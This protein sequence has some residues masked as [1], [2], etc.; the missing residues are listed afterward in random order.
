MKTREQKVRD[1]LQVLVED[2]LKHEHDVTFSL[3][4]GVIALAY[5]TEPRAVTLNV[6]LGGRFAAEHH[7]LTGQFDED[8]PRVTNAATSIVMDLYRKAKEDTA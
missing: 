5:A 7:A 6:S 3:D 2:S 4:A 8:A 1:G